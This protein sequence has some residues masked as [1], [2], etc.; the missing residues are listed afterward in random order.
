[1]YAAK[2]PGARPAFATAHFRPRLPPPLA[3]KHLI[4]FGHFLWL[5][6]YEIRLE[7]FLQ[8]AFAT[9]RGESD[10]PGQAHR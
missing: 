3:F 1:M 2:Q 4:A 9:E 10:V 5:T 8:G 6:K 7:S